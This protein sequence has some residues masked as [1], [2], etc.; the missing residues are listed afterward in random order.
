MNRQELKMAAKKSL[1]GKYGTFIGAMLIYVLVVL[2]IDGISFYVLNHIQTNQY[3]ISVLL[4]I[5][6]FI[7]SALFVIGLN[8]ITL[9]IA[10][11]EDVSINEL[12]KHGSLVLTYLIAQLLIVIFT[13]L[14]SLLLVIPGIVAAYGYMMTNFVIIDNPEL[15]PS[16]A[17]RQSKVMMRGYKL[18]FFILNLSFLGWAILA[19]FT[20]GILYFWLLPYMNVTYAKFY[21]M[22]KKHAQEAK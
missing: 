19:A 17:I 3:L 20:F 4:G 21:D 13:S 9:K 12:F 15:S 14:W 18:D 1:E 22:V 2:A 8:S 10:R 11:D 7:L 6:T 5:L 16:A